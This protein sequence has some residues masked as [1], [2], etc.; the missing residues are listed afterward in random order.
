MRDALEL[1]QV[2]TLPQRPRGRRRAHAGRRRPPGRHP[3]VPRGVVPRGAAQPPTQTPPAHGAGRRRMTTTE[4]PERR[5]PG[6][7]SGHHPLRRRLRRRHA[8]DRHPVHPDRRGLRQRHQHVPGLP[9]R[10]PRPRRHAA[11]RVGLPDQLLGLGH[12]HAGRPARR[13]GGDEPGRAQDQPRRPA[14][15][16]RADRQQRRVHPAEPEQGGLRLEP[17]RRRLAQARAP[18]F[19][20]PISTLNER[21][22][23]G[24]EHDVEAE[25]P[26]ARTSSRWA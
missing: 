24:L 7:R 17:A 6:A 13:A 3:Q 16:R 5:R 1:M 18:V 14:R 19:E 23:E 22:L 26:D 12:P 25:G 9:G 10:D 20:V 8:A 21:S 15:G 4:A 2:G 11:R